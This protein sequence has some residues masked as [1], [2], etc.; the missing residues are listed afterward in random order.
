MYKR[1]IYNIPI[2]I[3]KR[4]IYSIKVVK[5]ILNN[6]DDLENSINNIKEDN[7]KEKV[8]KV[9]NNYSFINDKKEVLDLI[10][11]DLKNTYLDEDNNGIKVSTIDDT[12]NNDD[13]V[14]L[15]GF[16]KENIP[17]LY[18]DNEYFSDKEKEVLGLDTSNELNIN[19]KIEVIR[20]IQ[21]IKNLTISYK[22]TDSNNTYT[23][24][25]LLNDIEIVKNYKHQYINSNMMN[26]IFL[27]TYL[28]NL[29]TVSYTH[30]DV[31]KR[32]PIY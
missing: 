16:N 11:N 32:Q 10:I 17:V 21:N 5:D 8:I 19:K 3:K 31:Y 23:R 14:F 9:L 28:D 22:L 7:I 24:S 13:Y 27:T 25:D 1:Q 18:K 20:M 30:L 6:L 15:L 29:V 12:Y 26:K 4:S 2:N